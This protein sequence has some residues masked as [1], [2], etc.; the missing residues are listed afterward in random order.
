[1]KSSVKVKWGPRQFLWAQGTN[2]PC[3]D[4]RDT[5]DAATLLHSVSRVI[6]AAKQSS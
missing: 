6:F 3:G 5:T 2:D 4:R 1:M